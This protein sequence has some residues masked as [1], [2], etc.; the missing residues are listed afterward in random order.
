MP[1][2]AMGRQK[3]KPCPVTLHS[4][5]RQLVRKEFDESLQ[6]LSSEKKAMLKLQEEELKKEREMELKLLRRLPVEE[7]GLMQ[8]AKPIGAVF[9]ERRQ[10]MS[11]SRISRDDST[12]GSGMNDLI[13]NFG[14]VQLG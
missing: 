2:S 12:F 11:L 10:E 5:K 6:R 4:E 9:S 8:I 3:L 1:P 13:A 14:A 7:G